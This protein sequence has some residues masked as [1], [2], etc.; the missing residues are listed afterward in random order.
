[1]ATSK[2]TA[3]AT[4]WKR[5][6]KAAIQKLGK[7]SAG[8]YTAELEPR[9]M[10]FASAFDP[11]PLLPPEYV[12]FIKALGYRWVSTGASALAFLPP[13]WMVSLAQQMGEPDRTWETVR[14]EREA[15]THAYRFVMFASRDLNDVNGFCFGKSEDS[16]ELVV[17]NV[18][19]SLPESELGPFST[20]IAE[21]LGALEAA[22]EETEEDAEPDEPLGLEGE[23]LPMKNKSG[24]AGPAAVLDA[25][26]RTAKEILLNGRKLGELPSMIGEFT[27]LESLWLR[28]TG[29]QQLP[30][31]LGL[32]GKLKKLDVSFNPALTALPPELGQLQSLESLN[33]NRTGLSTLPDELEQ[34]RRLTFLDLQA[35]AL[36]TLPP[37]LFRMPWLRTLDLYWT[38]I[39][40]EEIEQLRRA[41]PDCKV[42]VS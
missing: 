30:R 22:L 9:V 29:L 27:E 16:D 33:L 31:E 1:M 42:G 35:T 21:E 41:L 23:S 32:L 25:F 14:A 40:P 26:P 34:L 18:E 19:D 5:L 20:W 38:T 12:Q 7:H 2:K 15:G 3:P 4:A 28:T 37:V 36:K 10:P 11:G 39:P 8:R 6:E 24:K 17:W 13:R